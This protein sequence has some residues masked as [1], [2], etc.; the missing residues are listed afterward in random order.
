MKKSISGY[1]WLNVA[2]EKIPFG[3]IIEQTRFVDLHI[4]DDY[5][6]AYLSKYYLSDDPI[7]SM[8]D[9]EAANHMMEGIK[10]INP[11][12]EYS[13]IVDKYLYKTTTA[14][15][16][17]EI[18]FRKNIIDVN[19]SVSGLYIG[20]MMHVFPDERSINN[21][22]VVASKACQQ[23]NIDTSYVPHGKSLSGKIGFS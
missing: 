16:H 11:E 21:A 7:S 18:G 2:D 5:H 10:T 3:G 23:M 15:I 4:Y 14:A 8:N 9:E 19:T 6:I 1:Y 12:F 17:T 20:N 22:I 13:D